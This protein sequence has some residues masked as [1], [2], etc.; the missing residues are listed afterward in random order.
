MKLF[1]IIFTCLFFVSLIGFMVTVAMTGAQLIE[2]I[3]EGDLQIGWNWNWSGANWKPY[4]VNYSFEETYGNIEIGVLAARATI[5]PSLDDKTHIS[6]TGNQN[7][8]NVELI[9]KIENNTLIV[10]ES[11][12]FTS[13][14]WNWNWFWGSSGSGQAT[15]D[16]ELPQKFFDEID[17]NIT[18]GSLNAEL[19]ATDNLYIHIKSGSATLNHNHGIRSNHLKSN[20]ISGSVTINGFSPDTYDIHSTSGTQRINGLSGSGSVRLASGIANISFGEWDGDLRINITSGTANITVPGGSGADINFSRTSGSLSY[21]F[22]GD[23][24]WLNRSGNASVGGSNRQ[25]VNVSVT[26]GNVSIKNN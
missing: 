4:D 24:G 10:K 26:S 2:L 11:G 21:N 19:P 6:Y 23:S 20:T 3:R 5:R 8:T 7:H 25:K 1:I 9:V 16:I 22:D 13:S 17:I 14:G 15:L 12:W 18:S